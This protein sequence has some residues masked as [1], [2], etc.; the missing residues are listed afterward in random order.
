[1]FCSNK[2]VTVYIY[3]AEVLTS[4][5]FICLSIHCWKGSMKFICDVQEVKW[6]DWHTNH[7]TQMGKC[8]YLKKCLSLIIS[9]IVIPKQ[10]RHFYVVNFYFY[11][12]KTMLTVEIREMYLLCATNNFLVSTGLTIWSTSEQCKHTYVVMFLCK[13]W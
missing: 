6:P 9:V 1:M 4:F 11:V 2:Y 13:F 10:Q 12:D 5:H 3:K 7:V 8:T